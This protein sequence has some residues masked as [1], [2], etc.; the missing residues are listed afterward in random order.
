MPRTSSR[1][2]G[3]PV[4]GDLGLDQHVRQIADSAAQMALDE[5]AATADDLAID[6]AR[7]AVPAG[8]VPPAVVEV[9]ERRAGGDHFLEDA[10]EEGL[11]RLRAATEQRV[12]MA[13]LRHAFARFGDLR[14]HIAIDDSDPV[15]MSG[16]GAGGGET[17]H[18]R[19]DDDR[20]VL[21]TAGHRIP[22][23]RAGAGGTRLSEECD[24]VAGRDHRA[25][26][27]FPGLHACPAS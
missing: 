25:V 16:Q 9:E 24:E 21:T 20:V 8:L 7:G 11:D 26:G 27:F 12:G 22:P 15:E 2:V 10:G 4:D 13:A 19:T 5:R 6:V 14:D 17:A 18:A 23:R 1:F 3:E